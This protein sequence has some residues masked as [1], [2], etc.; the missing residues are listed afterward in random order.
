MAFPPVDSSFLPPSPPPLRVGE[1]IP[2][3]CPPETHLWSKQGSVWSSARLLQGST[4]CL[5]CLDWPLH[6]PPPWNGCKG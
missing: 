5:P 6:P 1:R 2:C 4:Q 3:A